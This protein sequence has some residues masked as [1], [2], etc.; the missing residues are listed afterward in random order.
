MSIRDGYRQ[1]VPC[2]AECTIQMD[3]VSRLSCSHGVVVCPGPPCNGPKTVVWENKYYI[4]DIRNRAS[5]SHVINTR[6]AGRAGGLLA[7]DSAPQARSPQPFPGPWSQPS[8]DQPRLGSAKTFHKSTRQCRN[9]RDSVNGLMFASPAGNWPGTP[10]SA[11]QPPSPE[12]RGKAT[13]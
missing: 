12:I 13:C 11:T 8:P 6:G 5:T 9:G 7:E 3:K 1:Q 2:T 10:H 4:P